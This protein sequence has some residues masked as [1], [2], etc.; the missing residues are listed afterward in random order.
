MEQFDLLFAAGGTDVL[1]NSL[2]VSATAEH[3]KI[4]WHR[5]SIPRYEHN[6][7]ACKC[8]PRV[9]YKNAHSNI[10]C[11]RSNWKQSKCPAKVIDSQ[12]EYWA[13]IKMNEPQLQ[14]TP[15]SEHH[16][17]V[18]QK[19]PH[20][21]CYILQAWLRVHNVQKQSKLIY[22]V[23]SQDSG[24]PWERG[25]S[26]DTRAAS[27]V[28]AFLCSYLHIGY[29]GMLISWK[30]ISLYTCDIYFLCLYW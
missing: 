8:P 22:D 28:I 15:W 5:H 9:K 29:T 12:K 3:G 14:R 2:A 23:E 21:K 1:E 27:V 7:K 30:F 20:T 19:S 4:S 10:V 25:V 17:H 24:Y 16:N 18:E 6:R 11:K 13:E 26:E